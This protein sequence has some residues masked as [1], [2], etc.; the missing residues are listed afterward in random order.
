MI[1]TITYTLLTRAGVAISALLSLI[2]TS[3]FLGSEVLGQ[4]TLL[5]LHIAIIHTIAEVFTGSGL[6]YFIPRVNTAS[7]YQK[8]LL[9]ILLVGT[10]STGIIYVTVPLL[11]KFGLHLFLLSV[12]GAMH[13]YHLFL[14]LGKEKIRMYNI[15]IL[16][17]PLVNLLVLCVAVF[18]L[19]WKNVNASII[20][21]YF[22]YG[23]SIITASKTVMAIVH[24]SSTA[25]QPVLLDI[26]AR[27]FVNQL[28]NLAH[29]L[30]NRFNYYVLAA[31]GL[32]ILGVYGSGTS[33]IE[34][35]WTVS[36]ALS[37]LVLSRVANSNNA[38]AEAGT[39]LRLATYSLLLSTLLVIIILMI[40]TEIFTMIL[41]KDF[42]QVK[43]VM[44]YLAPGVLALS[45]SSVISHYFSG[46]GMQRVL[47]LANTTGLLVT[48]VLSKVMISKLGI[49]G[50]CITASIAYA[51]QCLVLV[52]VFFK[53][54]Y[55]L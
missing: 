4:W 22:S 45:F 35:V 25:E 19:Q 48:L 37:P 32:S 7:L 15:L 12:F 10:I 6:V 54:R 23:V 44:L 30:S 47:L 13:N 29:M 24:V 9:W 51:M 43:V 28:G 38:S 18:Y 46:R 11:Q 42:S 3:R 20:A 2:I 27:G 8:G 16:L 33:L 39:S 1:K 50:A 53:E 41:G 31:S 36:A 14:L 26:L 55:K 40:P 17:Q 5:I 21:L 49:T 34:S 52:L